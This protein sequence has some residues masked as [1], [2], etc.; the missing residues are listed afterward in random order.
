MH[1]E[2]EIWQLI[3]GT[4]STWIYPLIRKPSITGSNSFIIRNENHVMVIDPGAIPDQ[5]EKIRQILASIISGP[6]HPVMIIAGHIHVDHMYLGLVDRQ[7]QEIARIIYV[8]ETWGARQLE[9]ATPIWTGA[10]V[11]GLTIADTQVD[12]HLLTADNPDPGTIR[13]VRI[14]GCYDISLTSH[15]YEHEGVIFRGESMPL[16]GGD[17]IEFWHTPGHSPDSLTIK[18]GNLIHVG[19]IP[20]STN[21]GIAGRPGW[22]RNDLLR[23]ATNISRH[24]IGQDEIICCPG[25]GRTLEKPATLAMLKKIEEDLMT[26]PE[27][28]EFNQER[29]NLSMWHGLDLIEEAHRIYPVIA[30]RLM[31]L[32]YHL[33]MLGMEEEANELA[34]ILQHENIDKFLDEFNFYYTEYKAGKK[35]KPEVVLKAL[36]IFER[37]QSS[38]S[39][40]SLEL[41]IDKSLIRRAT[42][43]TS[44]LLA[45]IQGTIPSGTIEQVAILPLIDAFCTSRLSPGINDQDL[46]DLA[47][48]EIAYRR[49]IVT[50]IAYHLHTSSLPL[51]LEKPGISPDLLVKIDNNRFLD[52]LTGITEY[53]E[54][55][56]AQT[57]LISMAVDNDELIITFIPKGTTINYTI[58]APGAT[59]RE[60]AYAGGQ[61]ISVMQPGKEDIRIRLPIAGNPR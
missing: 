17:R 35:V 27:I 1:L 26:L 16:P 34:P 59:L 57:V 18:I 33:E 15:Q 51:T 7:L 55:I 4:R 23:S 45:T 42:R 21:P 52:F 2:N 8:A 54:K 5:M 30:G 31:S 58:P 12:L 53:C 49:A 61:L 20:F 44:D 43:L 13:I 28:A 60:V 19:D 29:L 22:N 46:I 37:I 40:D 50:R 41:V 47:D 56:S 11:V 38:F 24:L 25:H 3:P 10:D 6:K 48:D 32:S 39:T 36:Q 14:P 9:K